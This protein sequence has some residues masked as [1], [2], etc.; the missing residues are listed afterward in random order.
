MLDLFWYYFLLFSGWMVDIFGNYV[1]AFVVLVISAIVSFILALWV[2]IITRK[3]DRINTHIVMIEK[4]VSQETI[5][6]YL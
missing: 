3:G 5:T 6:T 2:A 1:M 4:T